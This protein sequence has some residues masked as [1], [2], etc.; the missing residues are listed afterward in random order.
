MASRKSTRTRKY[1]ARCVAAAALIFMA[2]VCTHIGV[3]SLHFFIGLDSFRSSGHWLEV[4][5]IYVY[6]VCKTIPQTSRRQLLCFHPSAC[7]SLCLYGRQGA[8]GLIRGPPLYIKSLCLEPP[9]RFGYLTAVYLRARASHETFVLFLSKDRKLFQDLKETTI[10]YEKS[11]QGY[12][13]MSWG[14]EYFS[15]WSNSF[16]K[17]DRS[18]WNE[19]VDSEELTCL[20]IRW[21]LNK[22]YLFY[23]FELE[24][25]CLLYSL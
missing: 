5:C 24:K 17:W 13:E 9:A 16:L 25:G 3:P 4:V 18:I 12:A 7:G 1:N 23:Y 8:A 15:G 2:C 20:I 22:S 19:T 11:N 10:H 14:N 21:T 6:S